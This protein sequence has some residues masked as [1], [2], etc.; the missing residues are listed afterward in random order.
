MEDKS[1]C[2]D[3]F[4]S[5]IFS[6][7]LILIFFLDNKVTSCVEEIFNGLVEIIFRNFSSVFEIL[8]SPSI[9]IPWD[10]L[11]FIVDNTFN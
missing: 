6:S 3:D 2:V 1:I 10:S 4:I 7:E 11:P 9:F 8:I 5:H